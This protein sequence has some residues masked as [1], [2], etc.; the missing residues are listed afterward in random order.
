MLQPTESMR[1][2]RGPD[3]LSSTPMDMP[4]LPASARRR[5][6]PASRW[7]P[8]RWTGRRV[9]L[10]TA[11]LALLTGVLLILVPLSINAARRT[12]VQRQT[13]H[14]P[15][16]PPPLV[17]AEGVPLFGAG[18]GG[19]ASEDELD[20]ATTLAVP[21]E[22]YVAGA[23]AADAALFG[24][25]LNDLSA[26]RVNTTLAALSRWM[27]R[28]AFFMLVEP[29]Q[30]ATGLAAFAA[31]QAALLTAAFRGAGIAFSPATAVAVPVEPGGAACSVDAAGAPSPAALD[32]LG[33]AAPVDVITVLA[34]DLAGGVRG[35]S[36]V[37]SSNASKIPAL[38]LLHRAALVSSETALIH[39]V[40]HLL[41]LPHP[42]PEVATCKR[43]GDCIADTPLQHAANTGCPDPSTSDMNLCPGTDGAVPIYNFMDLT[44]DACRRTFTP[45]QT[46]RMRSMATAYRPLL[47]AAA[48]T[49]RLRRPLPLADAFQSGPPPRAALLAQLAAARARLQGNA[50]SLPCSPTALEV[51]SAGGNMAAACLG[52]AGEGARLLTA[53]SDVWRQ[54][55]GALV[56]GAGAGSAVLPPA[57]LA[58][59]GCACLGPSPGSNGSASSWT[60][61]LGTA[62]YVDGIRLLFPA[63]GPA[64]AA[65]EALT[66]RV[67]VSGSATPGTGAPCALWTR[68][69][70]AARSN[71]ALV[72]LEC[73]RP[74][75]GRWVHL[76]VEGFDDAS[77]A[78][79]VAG[80]RAGAAVAPAA[81][82]PCV[83]GVQPLSFLAQDLAVPA[84]PDG[85]AVTFVPGTVLDVWSRRRAGGRGM[86]NGSIS[87]GPGRGN[88]SVAGDDEVGGASWR[89]DLGLAPPHVRGV[90]LFLPAPPRMGVRFV[91]ELYGEGEAGSAP[92]A[93]CASALPAAAGPVLELDCRAFFPA[94][95]IVVRATGP[96]PAPALCGVE[97]VGG[98][99]AGVLRRLADRAASLVVRDDPSSQAAYAPLV[100]DGRLDTCLPRSVDSDA[101]ETTW[102]LDL[103][104]GPLP[105]L[106]LGV[107]AKAATAGATGA[108]AVEVLD[109][110]GASLWRTSV[111]ANST[112]PG[113]PAMLD[114]PRGLAATG[115]VRLLMDSATLLCELTLVTLAGGEAGLPIE[116]QIDS[117]DVGV[118]TIDGGG[119]GRNLTAALAG[120]DYRDCPD[121]AAAGEDL[122]LEISLDGALYS[123]SLVQIVTASPL[124]NVTLTD[125]REGAPGCVPSVA[126]NDTVPAGGVTTWNCTPALETRELV[127]RAQLEDGEDT[128]R[129]CTVR[130]FHEL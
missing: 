98:R 117:E 57:S 102:E 14:A 29:G 100:V 84:W 90:R 39:Q 96:G 3:E 36:A 21:Y 114:M 86:T 40:G 41:G 28:L 111:L 52:G 94:A 110:G 66:W 59:D 43:D 85:E 11:L 115:A 91:A 128:P 46:L 81:A 23:E 53:L 34:C 123:T 56:G 95:V 38:V 93:L 130:V 113:V 65:V 112:V 37:L 82:L 50:S 83:C 103:G 120:R 97:L 126:S 48:A 26:E 71:A 129:I 72:E 119:G 108:V 104:G 106:A 16:P 61:D 2:L 13:G 62:A 109:A 45:L 89:L 63:P 44:D 49:A 25:P 121:T 64:D 73:P 47:A 7:R 79:A 32:A 20:C 1:A 105:L 69:G 8:S 9:L 77:L 88:C 6:T 124:T 60:A 35:A 116:A 54:A 55:G 78:A 27:L 99:E 74:L 12:N 4:G 122:E 107:S 101:E 58:L 92:A 18:D 19:G 33:A 125:H 30:N 10:G 70:P 68:G 51:E 80:N 118:V 5:S 24:A 31:G 76:G 17:D 127:I 42:F 87:L 22:A 75:P 67:L 15:P